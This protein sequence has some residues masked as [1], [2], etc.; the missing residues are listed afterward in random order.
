MVLPGERGEEDHGDDD[1]EQKEEEEESQALSTCR[2][3]AGGRGRSIVILLAA[4]TTHRMQLGLGL[5]QSLPVPADG[6]VVTLRM[7]GVDR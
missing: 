4:W 2:R 1:V 6:D 5:T 3:E 7:R